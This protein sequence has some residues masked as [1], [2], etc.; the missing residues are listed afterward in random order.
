M[1]WHADL[2]DTDW[3]RG[4]D[5]TVRLRDAFLELRLGWITVAEAR[6]GSMVLMG[7][8][9]RNLRKTRKPFMAA[10]TSPQ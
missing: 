6:G 8:L 4:F 2:S 9:R 7:D 3:D 1:R 10:T 5:L